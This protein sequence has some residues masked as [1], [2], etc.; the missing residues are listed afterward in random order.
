MCKNT[1]ALGRNLPDIVTVQQDSECS[2][3]EQLLLQC[4]SD[5]AL[6]SSTQASEPQYTAALLQPALLIFAGDPSFMPVNILGPHI[7]YVS[8]GV[9]AAIQINAAVVCF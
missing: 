2:S 3:S 6:A 8:L 7:S 4:A 9:C 5:C 1:A